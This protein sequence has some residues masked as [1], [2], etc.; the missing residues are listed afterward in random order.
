MF[1]FNLLSVISQADRVFSLICSDPILHVTK[2]PLI[3]SIYLKL[4]TD[5][6]CILFPVIMK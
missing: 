5:Y 1:F 3:K 6:D 4:Q 2:L